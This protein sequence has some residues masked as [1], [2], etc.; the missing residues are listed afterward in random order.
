M[1]LSAERCR[2]LKPCWREMGDGSLG[3]GAI[4][5]SATDESWLLWWPFISK[6]VLMPLTSEFCFGLLSEILSSEF[7]VNAWSNRRP[8]SNS[9]SWPRKLKLGDMDGL[10][11]FTNLL[12]NKIITVYLWQSLFFHCF[13]FPSVDA[14]NI[15]LYANFKTLIWS[16]VN[17]NEQLIHRY[18]TLQ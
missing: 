13:F 7:E 4:C 3:S 1:I 2:P 8:F 15:V 10:R 18:T 14:I 9:S 11:S 12:W 17:W 16:K 6:H 5:S